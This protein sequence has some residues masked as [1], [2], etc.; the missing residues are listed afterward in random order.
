MIS[1]YREIDK[2]LLHQINENEDRLCRELSEIF[3]NKYEAYL[4]K[5]DIHT[6]IYVSRWIDKTSRLPWKQYDG[7]STLICV[8]FKDSDNLVIE[9]DENVCSLD[10]YITCIRYDFFK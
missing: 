5:H 8:D 1:F 3:Q 10:D 4:S 9:L 6:D 2:E 7:Y